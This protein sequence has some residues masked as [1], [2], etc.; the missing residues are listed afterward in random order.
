VKGSLLLLPC[1]V[2]TLERIG[3]IAET[4]ALIVFFTVREEALLRE[5]VACV[6]CV[7]LCADRLGRE[8]RLRVGIVHGVGKGGGH[9]VAA[10]W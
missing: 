7:R 5:G 4:E 2:N 10:V 9:A 1:L 6:R 3:D 8:V